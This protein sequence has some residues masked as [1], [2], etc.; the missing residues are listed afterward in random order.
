AT[1]R[2][3]FLEVQLEPGWKTYWRLPGRFGLAPSFDWSRSDNVADIDVLYPA[4]VLFAEGDGNSL[5]YIETVRLPVIVRPRDPEESVQLQLSAHLGMCETLCIPVEA[6]LSATLAVSRDAMGPLPQLS[7]PAV[8]SLASRLPSPTIA[9]WSE[10]EEPPSDD[11]VFLLAGEGGRHQLL[12]RMEVAG[13]RSA[14]ADW[15]YDAPP[16]ELIHIV[17]G[18]SVTRFALP[19][20]R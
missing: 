6:D 14:L 9:H 20:E 13:L 8:G 10:L 15:P 16:S 18:Q 3:L 11:A 7:P 12:R 5:G 4:P 1:S 19:S 2:L 17:L